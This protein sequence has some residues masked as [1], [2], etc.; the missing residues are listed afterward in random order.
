MGEPV[1]ALQ[2]AWMRAFEPQ[3][4]PGV[5]VLES[6]SPRAGRGTRQEVVCS[7]A[8]EQMAACSLLRRWLG[9]ALCGR[10]W[11]SPSLVSCLTRLAVVALKNKHLPLTSFPFLTSLR[12]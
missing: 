12:V 5:L 8:P 6:Q 4:C 11:Y 2:A 7:Q 3:E 1:T 9:P 10:A